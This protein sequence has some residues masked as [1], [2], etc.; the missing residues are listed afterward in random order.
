MKH[1]QR[2]FSIK[3]DSKVKKA[4]DGENSWFINKNEEPV[5]GNIV[6]KYAKGDKYYRRNEESNLAKAPEGLQIVLDIEDFI[7]K[8]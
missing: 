5:R 8:K 1:G 3:L 7:E 4:D 6:A 2:T